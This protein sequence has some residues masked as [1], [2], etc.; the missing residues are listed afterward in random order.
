MVSIRPSDVWNL[1]NTTAGFILDQLNRI[2]PRPYIIAEDIS[3]VF[4]TLEKMMDPSLVK[5]LLGVPDRYYLYSVKSNEKIQWL[6]RVIANLGMKSIAA[7]SEI[8]DFL[9]RVLSTY[10]I[11]ETTEDTVLKRFLIKITM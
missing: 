10:A 11:F 7:Q 2:M 3:K 8:R 6:E 9:R 5:L 1:Y 4:D